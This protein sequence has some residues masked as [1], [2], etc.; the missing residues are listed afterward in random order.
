MDLMRLHGSN[1][2]AVKCLL[3]HAVWT[4]SVMDSA[5]YHGWYKENSM[6]DY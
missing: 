4:T 2:V 6:Q 3:M 5:N 1:E